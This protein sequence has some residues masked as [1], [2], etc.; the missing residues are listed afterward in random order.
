[1]E[2]VT[3]AKAVAFYYK[4]KIYRIERYR[5]QSSK[6]KLEKDLSGRI[7][8]THQQVLLYSYINHENMVSAEIDTHMD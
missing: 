4:L 5:F 2:M 1:M 8:P 3:G 6:S 7:H